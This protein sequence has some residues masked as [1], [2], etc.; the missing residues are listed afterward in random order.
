M[1]TAMNENEERVEL[2]RRLRAH[3]SEGF[4]SAYE[5]API[6]HLRVAVADCDEQVEFYRLCGFEDMSRQEPER[7]A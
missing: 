6:E 5:K 1:T 4:A 7:A 2:M 3:V